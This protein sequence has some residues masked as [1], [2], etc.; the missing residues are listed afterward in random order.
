[1]MAAC[2]ISLVRFQYGVNMVVL[3]SAALVVLLSQRHKTR[4]ATPDMKV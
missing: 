2:D 1:M 4:I 3:V